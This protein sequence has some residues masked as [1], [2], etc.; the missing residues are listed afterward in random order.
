[1]N[2]CIRF[3]V[4]S[5]YA[6]VVLPKLETSNLKHLLWHPGNILIGGILKKAQGCHQKGFS[7]VGNVPKTDFNQAWWISP[8]W[9]ITILLDDPANKFWLV[10]I[11]LNL[12][13]LLVRK[14][15][16][17]INILFSTLTPPKQ[18]IKMPWEDLLWRF[19]PLTTCR[20]QI[21]SCIS[22]RCQNPSKIGRSIATR[23]VAWLIDHY[24]T[25]CELFGKVWSK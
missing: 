12:S 15:I 3:Q 2:P 11:C 17:I 22:Q 18:K 20:G 16:I 9:R 19:S 23:S 1:M 5:F 8:S 25:E 6:R 14:R 13:Y 7:R 24:S 10:W 21:E 4:S